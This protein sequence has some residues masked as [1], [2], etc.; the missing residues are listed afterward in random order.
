MIVGPT[1]A[2]AAPGAPVGTDKVAA[3]VDDDDFERL[4][5]AEYPK[6][7]RIAFALCGR[8][9]VAEELVQDAMVKVLVRWHRVR[10]YDNP[11]AYC[12]RVVMNESIGALRRRGREAHALARVDPPPDVGLPAEVAEVWSHVRA[13]PRRQMQVVV[14]FYVDDLPTADIAAALRTTDAN[15]RAALSKARAVLKTRLDG[16]RDE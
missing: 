9:D 2:G 13:L 6:L 5:R 4:Y 3:R 11:P 1:D 7:V 15:V 14:L 8:R 10:G 12:R 16:A